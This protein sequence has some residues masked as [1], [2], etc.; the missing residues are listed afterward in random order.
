[1]SNGHLTSPIQAIAMRDA[2]DDFNHDAWSSQWGPEPLKLMRSFPTQAGKTYRLYFNAMPEDGGTYESGV[3]RVDA[4]GGSIHFK[5][6]GSSEGMKSYAIEFT[7]TAATSSITFVNYGHV[8]NDWCDP[9]IWEWCTTN[10]RT[11]GAA[12]ELIIDDVV[13]AEAACSTGTISGRV[14]KDLN[15]N[16]SFDSATETGINAIKVSLYDQNGTANDT[17]DDRLVYSADSNSA[18]MYTFNTIDTTRTYRIEVDTADTDL[19]SGWVIGTTNPIL[20]VTVAANATTANQDFGFDPS[21]PPNL[22]VVGEHRF[23][24]CGG[25][26]WNVDSSGKN[27]TAIG[28]AQIITEDYKSYGCTAIANPGWSVEVPQIADYALASGAISILV[29]DNKNVWNDA[30]RLIDKGWNEKF[31]VNLQKVSDNLHGTVTVNLN[32]HSIDTGEVYYTTLNNGTLNDTQWTHVVVSFGPQ[33]MKLYINGV[34]KGTNAYTGGIQNVLGNFRLPGLEGYFD[35]FYIF[36]QQPTD[37]QVQQLYSNITTNKNWDGTERACACGGSVGD[38]GDAPNSYGSPVHSVVAG[39][40][41]GTGVPDTETNAQPSVLA[42][43]DDTNSN[44]DEDGVSIYPMWQ[45]VDS[46]ISVKTTGGGYLQAWM[47]WNA[48]GD[49][50]DVGEQVATN[51]SDGDAK[52]LNT[53]TGTIDFLVTPPANAATTRTY[54]R[55]RWSSAQNLGPSGA[56]TDGEVEDYEASVSILP[57]QACDA[58]IWYG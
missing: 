19:P 45:G 1:D 26:T 37:T 36:N 13:L 58:S 24:D 40:Y 20:N 15:K 50:N 30:S 41:L 47:D 46:Q 48:D 34:L 52:D 31:T 17:T 55:F 44:D 3:M 51:L 23:D 8:G 21:V 32:G 39:L 9:Q 7:A 18:G 33:G 54:A 29:Y 35:E 38:Y 56:A 28:T 14:Y 6:P 25:N 57:G 5:A 42:N 11:T 22:G 2:P 27:N 43:G 53:A 16:N 10:G 49:F 12:N 4:P